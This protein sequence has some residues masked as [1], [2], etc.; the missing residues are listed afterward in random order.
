MRRDKIVPIPK[1]KVLADVGGVID[2]SGVKLALY[3]DDLNPD[4]VT[5]L[6]KVKPTRSFKRG[7]RLKPTSRPMPHGAWFLEV[8]GKSPDGPEVLLRNLLTMLPASENVWKEI[9]ARYK[10]QIRFGLHMSGWNK[11]FEISST[12]V[13][14]L[15]NMGVD[16]EFD[17]YAYGDDD[18]DAGR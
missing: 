11:G 7:Y 15:G 12:L 13:R 5:D 8:R 2:E 14:R 10:A 9:K 16:L 17:I 18:E 3:G 6:L 1:P 4:V